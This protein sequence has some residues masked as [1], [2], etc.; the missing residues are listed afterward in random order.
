MRSDLETRRRTLWRLVLDPKCIYFCSFKPYGESLEACSEEIGGKRSSFWHVFKTCWLRCKC[1][2]H[3]V[4]HEMEHEE[5][6]FSNEFLDDRKILKLIFKFIS[7]LE[8]TNSWLIV[9]Q[10]TFW[11][12]SETEHWRV[13]SSL[14]RVCMCQLNARWIYRKSHQSFLICP[15]LTIGAKIYFKSSP[16]VRFIKSCISSASLQFAL[17]NSQRAMVRKH[18][19]L[20]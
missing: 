16:C 2:N 19:W 13:D 15:G 4:H 5:N 1:N 11:N 3:Q 9:W 6:R 10:N 12:K 20:K 17:C 18:P 14:M 7:G 8:P